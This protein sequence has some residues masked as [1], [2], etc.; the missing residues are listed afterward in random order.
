MYN[1][2]NWSLMFASISGQMARLDHLATILVPICLYCLN[3]TKFVQ[4]I[5]RKIINIVTIFVSL[6]ATL[7]ENG[8]PIC[9][10]FSGK[11]WSDHGTTW[12]NFGSIRVNG[13]AGQRSICSLSKLVDISF[14]LAWWQHFLSINT[15]SGIGHLVCTRS[16][17]AGGGVCSASH[18]SFLCIAYFLTRAS[19]V[20]LLIF[21]VF[22]SFLFLHATAYMLSA[23]YAIAI[24]S[25]CLSVCHTGGSVKN[26]WSWD[27]AIFT[28]Q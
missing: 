9:M 27:H 11:V 3:C 28:V 1:L 20:L 10:K 4:L 21:S 24:P 7:R 15:A 13:S 12:L 16:V 22:V 2:G 8:W 26:G 6:S 23:L 5:L 25:V 18:H 17:A 19:F 14:A